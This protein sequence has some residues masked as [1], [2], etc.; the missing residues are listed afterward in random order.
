[1]LCLLHKPRINKVLNQLFFS[2]TT[3]LLNAKSTTCIVAS[4]H[5]YFYLF[6]EPKCI[7]YHYGTCTEL[8][9]SDVIDEITVLSLKQVVL[10]QGI[11]MDRLVIIV[12]S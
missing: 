12:Q 4:I 8:C 11:W 2:E 6:A 9:S 7:E 1:M 10:L 5:L 3:I